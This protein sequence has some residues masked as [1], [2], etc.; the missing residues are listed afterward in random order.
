LGIIT[1]QEKKGGKNPEKPRLLL[2]EDDIVTINVIKRIL[3][4][5]YILDTANN[6]LEAVKIAKVNNFDAFLIDIGLPGHMNGIQIT[7]KNKEIK[8][9]KNKP[10]I[11]ITAYAMATDK[12]NILSQGLTHYISKP[13]KFSDLIKL[14][15]GAV[16]K[17]H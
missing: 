4:D 12:E 16:K 10:Y 6:G 5:A 15:E 13:F 9:N 2:G 14:I 1:M 11:A 17:Q 8:D 3:K 7:K